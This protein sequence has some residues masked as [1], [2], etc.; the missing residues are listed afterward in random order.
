VKRGKKKKKS[1]FKGSTHKKHKKKK[2]KRKRKK[3]DFL[4][5]LKGGSLLDSQHFINMKN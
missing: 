2:R 3:E 4:K 5:N 1:N